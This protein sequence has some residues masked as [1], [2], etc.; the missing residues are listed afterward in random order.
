MLK[1]YTDPIV[2]NNSNLGQLNSLLIMYILPFQ[3]SQFL[4]FGLVGSH[5]QLCT[6]HMLINIFYICPRH[7]MLEV[8]V[9]NQDKKGVLLKAVVSWP[10]RYLMSALRG[11]PNYPIRNMGQCTWMK[12]RTPKTE[13]LQ[14]V[15]EV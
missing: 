3:G 15:G 5:N 11:Y 7:Q 13:M 9:A 1:K 14:S 2:K 6:S 8:E 10:T 4:Y 12:V